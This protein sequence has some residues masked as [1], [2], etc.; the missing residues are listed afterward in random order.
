M[1]LVETRSI[2]SPGEPTASCRD[3]V[4]F[5]DDPARLEAALP[6]LAILS[7][8][9]GST[10]GRAGL[11]GAFGRFHDPIPAA[12]CRAFEARVRRP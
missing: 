10:R 11:C 7:S 2:P 1:E 4:H 6:N 5:E 3:C 9:W 8:A 12:G